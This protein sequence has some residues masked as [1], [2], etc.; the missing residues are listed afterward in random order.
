MK[1]RFK[2]A[3][4]HFLILVF[5]LNALISFSQNKI[6]TPKEF[7]GFQMGADY[8]L[9]RWDKIIHYFIPAGQFI[10]RSHL[11]PKKLLRCGNFVL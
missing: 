2:P 8:K 1:N 5:I 4:I 11:K 6:T 3:I 7:F 10:I 9:A